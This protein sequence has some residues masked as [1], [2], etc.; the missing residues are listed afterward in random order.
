MAAFSSVARRI[1]VQGVAELVRLGRAHRLDAG[2]V[3][4][5][6]V[7]SVAA[8]AERTEQ[9]AQR[10]V[11]EKVERLVGDLERRRRLIL[12]TL[13]LAASLPP[14]ALGL[15]IR[16]RGDVAL[17]R[18]AFDDLLDQLFQLRARVLL[19]AVR[20]IAQQPL[21]CF[22]RQHAAVEQRLQNRVVQRLHR[23]LFLVRAVRITEAAREEQIRQLRHEILE[24]QIVERVARELRVAVLHQL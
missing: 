5:S 11:A 24:I 4:A 9:I 18:H 17:F 15:E 16:R 13:A 1:E 22:F 23:P 19:I 6:V 20:G 7:P 21:D 8:L 12:S 14:F 2:G 3:L 10:A